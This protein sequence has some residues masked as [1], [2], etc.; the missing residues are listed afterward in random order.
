MSY[1]LLNPKQLYKLVTATKQYTLAANSTESVE[2]SPSV[3]DGYTA[4]AA[5]RVSSGN[6]SVAIASFNISGNT[7]WD[8][9]VR[10]NSGSSITATATVVALCLQAELAG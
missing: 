6:R 3:P 10:N 5:K 4:V 1:T 8:I 9:A 7:A 2:F